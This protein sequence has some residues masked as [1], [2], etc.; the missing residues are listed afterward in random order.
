MLKLNLI[1]KHEALSQNVC[2]LC[3]NMCA[4][5]ENRIVTTCLTLQCS[6]WQSWRINFTTADVFGW[7]GWGGELHDLSLVLQNLRDFHSNTYQN[8]FFN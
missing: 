5:Y 2:L 6:G 4:S 8:N 1:L 3:T 7:S